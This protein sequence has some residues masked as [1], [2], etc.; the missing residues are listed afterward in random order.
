MP[1]E[2]W[3]S[4]I[5]IKELPIRRVVIEAVDGEI[6]ALGILLYRTEDIVPAILEVLLI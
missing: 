6:T 5:E 2:I 4:I 1:A 3:Q